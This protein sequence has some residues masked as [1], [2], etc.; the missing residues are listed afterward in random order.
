VDCDLTEGLGHDGA[1]ISACAV[2]SATV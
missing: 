2:K 1:S